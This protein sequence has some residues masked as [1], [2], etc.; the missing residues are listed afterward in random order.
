VWK[1]V[2]APAFLATTP[3]RVEE[4]PATALEGT[5]VYGFS[6]HRFCVASP[7]DA[8]LPI[9][10]YEPARCFR[11]HCYS[12]AEHAE[13]AAYVEHVAPRGTPLA[14]FA[15][16]PSYAPR[17]ESRSV[18]ELGVACWY[19][20]VA[21]PSAVV[22]PAESRSTAPTKTATFTVLSAGACPLGARLAA[23]TKVAT[24]EAITAKS[25]RS[26][27]V[28]LAPPGEHAEAVEI[29]AEIQERKDDT[30]PRSLAATQAPDPET[31]LRYWLR[32][33]GDTLKHSIYMDDGRWRR[34]GLTPGV[35]AYRHSSVGRTRPNPPGHCVHRVEFGECELRLGERVRVYTSEGA[36]ADFTLY[37]LVQCNDD[38]GC[39]YELTVC[40]PRATV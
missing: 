30:A 31:P 9:D 39:E 15:P 27:T 25:P 14:P 11:I 29:G 19:D 22:W 28:A 1:R 40:L 12:P 33:P 23:A 34:L 16:H 20:G 6:Q 26:E 37:D 8:T 38:R 3:G 35:S 4:C 2:D 5:I 10:T 24:P 36:S 18:R 17:S 32:G 13:L 7:A 21:H